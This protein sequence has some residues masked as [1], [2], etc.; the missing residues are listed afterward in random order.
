MFMKNSVVVSLVRKVLLIVLVM[1]YNSVSAGV[2]VLSFTNKKAINFQKVL[3]VGEIELLEFASPVSLAHYGTSKQSLDY[4]ELE[5]LEKSSAGYKKFMIKAKSPGSGVLTFQSGAEVIKLKVIVKENYS[6]LESELNQ[7]FGTKNISDTDKIKV[8][9]ANLV[10]DMDIENGPKVFLRGKVP[11]AKSAMLAVAFAANALGDKGVKIFSNPG[12]QLR[13]KDLDSA[14]LNQNNNNQQSLQ[15]N[16][17]SFVETYESANKL[18][19]TNNIY[20]DLVLASENER[21]ISFLEVAEPKRYAVKVRFLE[22]DTRTIDDFMS[23]ISATSTLNEVSGGAGTAPI[24]VPSINQASGLG[25]GSITNAIT[26]AGTSVLANQIS[27]GNLVSGTVKLLDNVFLNVDINNL[28]NEGALRVVNEFSLITHSGEA[29]ALGKGTRFPIPQINNS[30]ANSS[31]TVEYIPIGFK[32]ELKVTGLESGLIDVQL[33]SRLSSAESSSTSIAGLNVPI[34][35]EEYV[36][37]GA[38][39]A[40]GQEVVLNAFLTESEA[41]V[42]STSPLGRIIPFIGSSKRKRKRKNLLFIAIEAEEIEPSSVQARSNTIELPHIDVNKRRNVYAHHAKKMDRM[43]LNS[44]L[45]LAKLNESKLQE[46]N[47]GSSRNVD[48]LDIDGDL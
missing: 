11:D 28:L 35:T 39:L 34:F 20:R 37:S 40:D 1:S 42:N 19:D 47:T 41:N 21:V 44:D 2:P 27:S 46:R 29:V 14:M 6:Y 48:A 15:G 10:S 4:I 8:V 12:G 32:G 22:M 23:S 26:A 3:N 31:I 33:A 45:D 43:D 38:M 9:S 5:K 7:L 17:Q 30:L 13:M 16:N 18:I 36:N 24:P 25:S